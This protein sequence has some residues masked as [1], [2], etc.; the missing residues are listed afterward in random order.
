MNNLVKIVQQTEKV[1][2]E[3]KVMIIILITALI[4]GV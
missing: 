3:K 2:G 4:F 1:D